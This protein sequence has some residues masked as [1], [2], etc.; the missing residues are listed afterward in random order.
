MNEKEKRINTDLS[1]LKIFSVHKPN[2]FDNS[3]ESSDL[4]I[5]DLIIL[6]PDSNKVFK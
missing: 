4:S 1:D 6:N 3:D 5:L 2:S